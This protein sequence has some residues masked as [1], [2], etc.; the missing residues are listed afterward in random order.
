MTSV[1]LRTQRAKLVAD[2]RAIYKLAEGE[3]R[4]PNA[5][6]R[7]QFD[8]I[9]ADVDR[10]GDE[11]NKLDK[12]ELAERSLGES[13]GRV[14][15]PT[16]PETPATTATRG[17]PRASDEYRAAFS[18]WLRGGFLGVNARQAQSIEEV[19]AIQA[20]NLVSAGFLLSP[21]QFQ[22]ELIKFVD[23]MVF[24]RTLARKFTVTQAHSLGAPSLDADP[25][26]SDWTSELATGTD[27]TSFAF[28][29]RE[30]FP[31][32]LAKRIKVSNKMIRMLPG[33]DYLRAGASGLQVRR[34]RGEGVSDRQRPEPAARRVRGECER[35]F[36]RPRRDDRH[37][38]DLES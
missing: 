21:Q 8:R 11:A 26:D 29:K 37:R 31:R 18:A 33:I 22:N 34:D 9:M 14:S 17:N 35:H 12:L 13:A 38:G 25:A 28:G 16:T 6:E 20:D 23:N 5:E 30:L 36:H 24:M 19:R 7:E 10:L 4:S 15:T 1:E 2:A 3:K 32:P 27:D